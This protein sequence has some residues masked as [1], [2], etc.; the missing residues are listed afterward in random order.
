M[1]IPMFLIFLFKLV[2]S[3][4]VSIFILIDETR[5]LGFYYKTN[6]HKE[7]II[8]SYLIIAIS[9]L[10]K[11]IIILFF[12]FHTSMKKDDV[13]KIIKCIIVLIS[14]IVFAYYTISFLSF[15]DAIFLN[16]FMKIFSIV[17]LC[18]NLPYCF[19]NICFLGYIILYKIKTPNGSITPL[20]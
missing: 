1:I 14:T 7:Y 20:E 3:L 4:L 13:L 11:L 6:I 8:I 9:N 16:V 5:L 10:I 15:S 12:S 2:Y 18:L 19:A 17:N